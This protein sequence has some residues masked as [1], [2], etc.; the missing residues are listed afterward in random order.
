MKD[1]PGSYPSL[2]AHTYNPSTRQAEELLQDQAGLNS[3]ILSQTSNPQIRLLCKRLSLHV[4]GGAR[5][6]GGSRS[7]WSYLSSN[8]GW[9]S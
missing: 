6:I 7:T 9:D 8:P 1:N 2:M 5:K 3:E 4:K